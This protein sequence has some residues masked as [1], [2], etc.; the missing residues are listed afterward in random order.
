MAITEI[1]KLSANTKG[2]EQGIKQASKLLADFSKKAYQ[3]LIGADTS[4]AEE[5]ISAVTKM[6]EDIQDSNINVTAT[7]QSA[8]RS[9]NDIDKKVRG[10]EDAD[11]NV[12]ADTTQ[13]VNAVDAVQRSVENLEDTNIRVDADTSGARSAIKNVVSEVETLPSSFTID[14]DADE[15]KAESGIGSVKAAIA[16]IKDFTFN[17]GANVK[18]AISGIKNVKNEL[19]DIKD[20][21]INLDTSAASS[22][23]DSLSSVA[24]SKFTPALGAAGAAGA[25]AL[26]AGGIVALADR[27]AELEQTFSVLQARTGKTDAELNQL[28]ET[29]QNVFAQG[30]GESVND[31]VN[32]IALAEQQL[33]EF[34]DPAQLESFIV[35]AGGIGKT[36]DKDI[37][38]VIANSRTAIINFNTDG[39][40]ALNNIS[41]ALQKAGNAADDVLDTF[42]EYSPRAAEAGLSIE[43]FTSVLV[44]GVQAGARD[45]D[46]LADAIS[47]ANTFLSEGTSINAFDGI[48]KG[49]TGAEKALATSIQNILIEAKK[50]NISTLEALTLSQQDIEQALKSGNIS[51]AFNKELNIAIAGTP[52]EELG[53]EVFRRTFTAPL[54]VDEIKKQGQEA[55]KL[56]EESIAPKGFEGLKR[57]FSL[58]LDDLG[59]SVFTALSPVIDTL[60]DLL[61]SLQPAFKSIGS[62]IQPILGLL[63]PLLSLLEP[64]IAVA[65]TFVTAILPPLQSIFKAV[66]S[67]LEKSFVPILS[68]M[69]PVL[70]NLYTAMAPILSVVGTL[71]EY[72]ADLINFALKP[73]VFYFELWGSVWNSVITFIQDAGQYIVDLSNKIYGYLI[74]PIQKTNEFFRELWQVMEAVVDV[75]YDSLGTAFE[76]LGDVFSTVGGILYDL[77]IQPLVDLYDTVI[78]VG[79]AVL[80]FI[81]DNI[82]PLKEAFNDV[83][84]VVE[85]VVN[86]IGGFLSSVGSFF[87]DVGD[88]QFEVPFN[89]GYVDEINQATVEVKSFG[90]QM[91]LTGAQVNLSN[92]A[93]QV[94]FDGWKKNLKDTNTSGK[95]LVPTLEDLTK[96]LALL[97]IAGK[98]N[99]DQYKALYQEVVNQTRATNEYNDAVSKIKEQIKINLQFE[100][101]APLEA[102]DTASLNIFQGLDR[103]IKFDPIV[104]TIDAKES[105]DEYADYYADIQE[106]TRN[107]AL[108][109]QQ[110][111]TEN[112]IGEKRKQLDQELKDTQDALKNGEISYEEASKRE[113]EIARQQ[114]ELEKEIQRDKWADI[115]ALAGEALAGQFGILEEQSRTSLDK[116]YGD[117]QAYVDL[118]KDYGDGGFNS[119]IDSLDY[120]SMHSSEIFSNMAAQAGA[121]FGKMVASGE[122]ALAALGKSILLT[123][124]DNVEKI[125]L[126]NIPAIFTTIS[127]AIP[128]PFGQI[129]AGTVIATGMGLL[130][131][132]K[133]KIG[134]WEGGEI[135]AG[136]NKPAHPKDTVPLWTAPGEYI[137]PVD[138]TKRNK[139]LLEYLRAGGSE[140]KYFIQKYGNKL[141]S[142]PVKTGTYDRQAISEF[143]TMNKRLANVEKKLDSATLVKGY[144]THKTEVKQTIKQE[145]KSESYRF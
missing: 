16:N 132:A 31:A 6:T 53:I 46:K 87:S 42:N 112:G 48:I 17:I 134:A 136:Y 2:V 107:L 72:A 43:E 93:S 24:S 22:N 109:F 51:E 38:E 19:D 23:I 36:F 47:E 130:Q 135:S 78:K 142:Q 92:V 74:T 41:L 104:P 11:I 139:G 28:K 97:A 30:V 95:E 25:V 99:T 94:G 13:A 69:L 29:A 57:Q 60:G 137:M 102:I 91:G 20:V 105:L 64:L 9:L 133:S 141:K 129:L 35:K 39:E 14:L 82:L 70:T 85:D 10:L 116:I 33:G 26:L 3:A 37:T 44:S 120:L 12:D 58:I 59:T 145:L 126:A 138:A 15:S 119:L 84:G 49:A 110:D 75:I 111:V 121:T 52:A 79:G 81:N 101:Q 123:V 66:S 108:K 61:Q 50:G 113:L 54:P 98:E 34:L 56:I 71:I 103:Q 124:I 8:V 127:A 115:G 118:F 86:G 144:Y 62:L 89:E 63:T 100:A 128:P 18:D 32:S 40:T 1:I 4:D 27:G 76:F 21:E 131:V 90:E 67:I 140:E 106:T 5:K 7:T 96:K 88:Q 143:K 77:F 65:Q 55:G 73:V 68:S 83:Y 80:G 125:V 117:M 114:A 122:N 45:T